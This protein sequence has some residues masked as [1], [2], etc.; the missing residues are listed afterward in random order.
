MGQSGVAAVSKRAQ[1][2]LFSTV[3]FTTLRSFVSVQDAKENN[4]TALFEEHEYH[5]FVQG[6]LAAMEYQA[7][8][9]LMLD[10]A[11][12]EKERARG[13][14]SCKGGATT[15]RDGRCSSGDDGVIDSGGLDSGSLNTSGS[16]VDAIGR[17]YEERDGERVKRLSLRK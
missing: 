5:G 4:Y 12:A 7:F 13:G 10:A 9:R 11:A 6:L 16:S 3:D 17:R 15:A 1:Q 2:Y 8:Y 14:G